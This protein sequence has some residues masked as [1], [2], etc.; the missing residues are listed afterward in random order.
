M[1]R[2]D[3]DEDGNPVEHEDRFNEIDELDALFD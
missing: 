1:D 2:Y 3:I